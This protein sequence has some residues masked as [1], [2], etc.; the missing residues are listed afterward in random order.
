M[1]QKGFIKKLSIIIAVVI[2]ISVFATLS[3]AV[4][5][6]PSGLGLSGEQNIG[7]GPYDVDGTLY[8]DA[9][10]MGTKNS[11][12]SFTGSTKGTIF[13]TT[14]GAGVQSYDKTGSNEISGGGPHAYEAL[15]LGFNN[16]VDALGIDLLLSRYDDKKDNNKKDKKKKDK[17]S[18]D[19]MVYLILNYD[20][21]SL[22][23]YDANTIEGIF[24]PSNGN[25]FIKF[26]LLGVSSG[27]LN[28]IEVWADT[29]SH[30]VVNS[31]TYNPIPEPAT[32][33]LFG[34]GLSGLGLIGWR[35]KKR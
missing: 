19:D 29:G 9:Y 6:T 12:G 7:F 21:G 20:N 4:E 31:I 23:K 24:T 10:T 35:R 17:K 13:I 11:D 25:L 14:D 27:A 34:S 1:L 8:L 16:P 33:L 26:D 2:S 28:S 18:Q 32:L 22:L 3:Y 30:F 5:L 15:I